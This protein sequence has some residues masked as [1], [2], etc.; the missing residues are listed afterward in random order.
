MHLLCVSTLAINISFNNGLI[1]VLSIE[2]M[3]LHVMAIH[4]FTLHH[5]S[6]TIINEVIVPLSKGLGGLLVG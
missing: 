2:E 6:W 3:I 1:I 5:F 4:F